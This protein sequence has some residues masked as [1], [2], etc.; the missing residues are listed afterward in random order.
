M[1]DIAVQVFI[2]VKHLDRHSGLRDRI[3]AAHDRT[4]GTSSNLINHTV[5]KPLISDTYPV[6][7]D[8]SH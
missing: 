4:E 6:F 7:H 5:W 1:I 2:L 3:F 8:Y